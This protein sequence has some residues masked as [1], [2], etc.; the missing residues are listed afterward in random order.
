MDSSEAPQL[1]PE[2]EVGEPDYSVPHISN[3]FGPDLLGHC[4]T[5]PLGAPSVLVLD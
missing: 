2:V 4:V 5:V 3:G 1:L